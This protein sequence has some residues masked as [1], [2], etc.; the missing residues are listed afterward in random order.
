MC[1]EAIE[2]H[3]RKSHIWAALLPLNFMVT[4][5]RS[6]HSTAQKPHHILLELLSETTISDVFT[7]SQA[8]FLPPTSP[9][10]Q[11]PCFI[12]HYQMS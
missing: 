10:Q 11:M 5:F 4:N 6:A 7:F 9:S 1:T 3:K 12:V 8:C 2:Y